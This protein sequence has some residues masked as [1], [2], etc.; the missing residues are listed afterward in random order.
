MI[1]NKL[2]NEWYCIGCQA[3]HHCINCPYIDE[4]EYYHEWLL[5]TLDKKE[6]KNEIK[7]RICGCSQPILWDYPMC[8]ECHWKSKM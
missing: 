2:D 5:K 7:Q 4:L 3:D 6:I 1:E 8:R